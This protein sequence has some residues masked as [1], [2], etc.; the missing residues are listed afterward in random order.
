MRPKQRCGLVFCATGENI[1]MDKR[2]TLKQV[3][4]LTACSTPPT[5]CAALGILGCGLALALFVPFGSADA[6]SKYEVLYSFG[7]QANDGANP[8]AGL[9]ADSAGNLYGTTFNGGAGTYGTVFRLAPNG[10][11]WRGFKGEKIR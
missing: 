2:K 1:M 9:I 5:L 8:E 11:S 3:L 6:K 4:K 7:A 10:K